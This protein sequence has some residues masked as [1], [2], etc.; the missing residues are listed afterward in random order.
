M[1]ASILI[2][3]LIFGYAGWTLLSYVKKTKKGKCAGCSMAKTCA[4]ACDDVSGPSTTHIP[5]DP[6][7]YSR[8]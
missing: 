5:A 2:G 7:L 8:R 1:L 3:V 4:S 6:D